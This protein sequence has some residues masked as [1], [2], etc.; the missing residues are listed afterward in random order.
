MAAFAQF[1]RQDLDAAT[2]R[3]LAR[4]ERL[5]EV[6]KQPEHVTIPVENQVT[7]FYLATRGHLDDVEAE[8]IA[9]FET[10]W[11][12]YA[13]VNAAG[14]LGDIRETR[15]LSE[16]SQK[17]LDDAVGNFKETVFSRARV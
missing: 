4:G 17:K 9:E 7:I 1:G 14:V 5:T 2:L 10:K 11:Y 6:L 12:E 15:E 13:E 8:D 16:D 3:Q